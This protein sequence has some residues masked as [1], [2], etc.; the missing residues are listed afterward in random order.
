MFKATTPQRVKREDNVE[1]SQQ[2]PDI[3]E[4]MQRRLL[5][6]APRDVSEESLGDIYAA[7]MRY[8]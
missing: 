5:E 6:N 3:G 2:E 4:E 1:L 8:W 7:A